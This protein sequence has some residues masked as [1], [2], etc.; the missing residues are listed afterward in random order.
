SQDV[1]FINL[2]DKMASAMEALTEV[3]VTEHLFFKRDH[4]HT[5]ASGA[6]L[7]SSLIVEGIK[8]LEDC[9]LKNYLLENPQL[10]FPVKKHVF[11]IGD[12]TV[13]NGKDNKIGWGRFLADFMDT[14][15][16]EVVNKARGGRSSRSYRYEGLWQEVLDQIGEG[17]FLLVQFGHND[18]GKID[19]PKYRGSIIGMS[20]SSQTIIREDSITEVVHTYGWYMKKYIAEAKS[21]GATVIV[22]S[23]I[24]R[25]D[26]HHAKV[27][28][29][30]KS[31][32]KWSQEAADAE[33][34]FFINLNN[35]IALV[36]EEMGS[37]EV[38]RLFPDDHTH[39][40]TEGAQLNAEI[41]SKSIRSLRACNLRR[42]LK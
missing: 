29:N 41:L 24:P 10:V 27:D 15:R 2:N 18:S 40:N 17:D 30:D 37:K 25:N 9:E 20:D 36:Y 32:G 13:A 8:G 16:V 23:H 1:A 31:Y 42:Y 3:N 28:R 7:A 33:D 11:I 38:A 39:T 14:T 26:W 22:L 35:D 5:S 6:V 4:T 34:A 12:S 21:K 19:Q